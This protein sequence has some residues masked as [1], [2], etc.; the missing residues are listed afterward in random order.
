MYADL[1]SVLLVWDRPF[2]LSPLRLSFS[3]CVYS[4]DVSVCP[5]VS[6]LGRVW[7]QEKNAVS[8]KNADKTPGKIAD[9]KVHVVGRCDSEWR[10]TQGC[11]W[12][13]VVKNDCTVGSTLAPLPKNQ[14]ETVTKKTVKQGL[15]SVFRLYEAPLT[16]DIC[17][18]DTKLWNSDLL[19]VTGS[20]F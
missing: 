4:L 3:V 18:N 15:M 13:W 16:G 5:V 8:K 6:V 10:S 19:N 2:S 11:P 17:E 12:L 14:P 20:P 1:L 7:E 9:N